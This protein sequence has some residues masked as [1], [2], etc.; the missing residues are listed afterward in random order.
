MIETT[1]SSSLLAP[2]PSNAALDAL[3]DNAEHFVD[4]FL[5]NVTNAEIDNVLEALPDEPKTFLVVGSTL[6]NLT[7]MQV[8]DFLKRVC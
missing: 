7:V 5:A 6:I 2:A 8:Q 3:G 4:V 1:T